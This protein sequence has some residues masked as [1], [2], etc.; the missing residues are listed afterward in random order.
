M[1]D[2]SVKPHGNDGGGGLVQHDFLDG[3]A[4]AHASP[5]SPDFKHAL[6]AGRRIDERERMQALR[7]QRGGVLTTPHGDD[8]M[9]EGMDEGAPSAAATTN[10]PFAQAG[11]STA[12]QDPYFPFAEAVPRWARTFAALGISYRGATMRLD[13]CDRDGKYSNGFC[14]WPQPAFRGAGGRSPKF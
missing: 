4:A 14:H 9:G 3:T 8:G 2:M 12:A 1:V 10:Q 11:A 6:D 5:M 13:L 7:D